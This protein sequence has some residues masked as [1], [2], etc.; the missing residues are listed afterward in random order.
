[1][2]TYRAGFPLRLIEE[3]QPGVVL[4]SPGPGRPA[5]FG[6]PD[7]VRHAASLG[8][9]VFGVCL[10]LQGIVEAFGGDLD[11][12]RPGLCPSSPAKW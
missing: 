5:D 6:V 10:G 2:V 12:A 3:T 9:P 11:V 8:I 1:V 4:I 7:V